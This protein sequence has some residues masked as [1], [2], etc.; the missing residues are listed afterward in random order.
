MEKTL[1]IT[2]Y[3]KTLKYSDRLKRL[4]ENAKAGKQKETEMDDTR[5]RQK[6]ETSDDNSSQEISSMATTLMLQEGLS[7]IEAL[8]KATELYKVKENK[9]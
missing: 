2:K 4:T 6:Q 8:T 9:K 5:R 7:F 1:G 3:K